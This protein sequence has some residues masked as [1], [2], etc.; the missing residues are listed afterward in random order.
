MSA[1]TCL[2]I[3]TLVAHDRLL[4]MA[5]MRDVCVYMW[6][7]WHERHSQEHPALF[8]TA[9]L[10]FLQ[11]GRATARMIGISNLQFHSRRRRWCRGYML[12]RSGE[13]DSCNAARWW[14]LLLNVCM[15]IH[16]VSWSTSGSQ[17]LYSRRIRWLQVCYDFT[18]LL[19]SF[20]S[21]LLETDM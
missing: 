11:S 2:V 9:G 14:S 4:C 16:I 5:G 12:T 15:H 21:R 17:L 7:L 19:L 1:I 10:Q 20:I 8:I 3:T 18:L 6:Q 13:L